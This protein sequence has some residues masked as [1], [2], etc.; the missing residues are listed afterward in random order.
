MKGCQGIPGYLLGMIH[1]TGIR[2]CYLR[3]TEAKHPP[4][5]LHK[6]LTLGVV[7]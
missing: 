7:S 6:R 2:E 5:F 3:W 1:S 4:V